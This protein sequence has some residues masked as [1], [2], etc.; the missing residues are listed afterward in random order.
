MSAATSSCLSFLSP[1]LRCLNISNRA[2]CL[3]N[4]ARQAASFSEGLFGA[5]AS[6]LEISRESSAL[7]QKINSDAASKFPSSLQNMEAICAQA[8]GASKLAGTAAHMAQVFTGSAFFE[9]EADG[10]FRIQ[11]QHTDGETYKPKKIAKS[12]FS[13]A[14]NISRL[15]SN[16]LKGGYILDRASVVRLGAHA[17][18]VAVAG[19]ILGMVSSAFGAANDVRSICQQTKENVQQGQYESSNQ[20][21]RFA[22]CKMLFYSLLCNLVDILTELVFIIFITIPQMLGTYAALILGVFG[23]LSYAGNFVSD[24]ISMSR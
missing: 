13:I 6:A 8:A 21:S 12:G 23:F 22:K 11:L 10:S 17:N 20:P 1:Q 14:S 18:S 3:A 7:Q 4:N 2:R 15:A 19:G 9:T 5:V 24:L 16:I